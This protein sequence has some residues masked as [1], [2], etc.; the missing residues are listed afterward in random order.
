MACTIGF[1]LPQ[2]FGGVIAICGTNPLPKL[3]YLRHRVHD[4]LSVAFVTG[5][6]DFNRKENEDFMFPLFQDLSI[7]SRLWVVPKLGHG[8]PGPD[9][10]AAVQNGSMPT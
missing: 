9:V 5:A 1:A 2:Y 4:R 3:D 6:N 8:I 7:R 10:L